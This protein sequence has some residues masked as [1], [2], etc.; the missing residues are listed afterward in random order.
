MI[1]GTSFKSR[2]WIALTALAICGSTPAK[3]ALI[4][5]AAGIY[6]PQGNLVGYTITA[7]GTAGE[8]INT[9]TGLNVSAAVGGLGV[10]N[11]AQAFTNAGTPTKQQHT[12]GIWAADWTQYDTHFLYNAAETLSAGSNFS[13]TNNGATTG[14]LGLSMIGPNPPTSG[15]GSYNASATSAKVVLSP[16][17]DSSVPFFYLVTRHQDAFLID[18]RVDG[19]RPDGSHT[20]ANF[21]DY[22]FLYL[23]IEPE[24]TT[25]VLFALAFAGCFGFIRRR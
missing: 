1:F 19:Q 5:T 18:V 22:I 23:P 13:E 20:F 10:H 17:A 8:T 6:L 21:D 16:N 7:V 3:A 9:F 24:P 4:L 11:V 15:F 14:T 2:I 25:F 12:P